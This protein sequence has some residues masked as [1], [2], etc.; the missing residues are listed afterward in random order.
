[1]IFHSPS[2]EKLFELDNANV[3]VVPFANNQMYAL[4]ETS[5]LVKVNPKNLNVIKTENV[6]KK[7]Y[8]TVTSIAHPH[9]EEDGSW[10]SIG[11]RPMSLNIT[12]DIMRYEAK[13]SKDVFDNPKLICQ[14][15]SSHT[16]GLSYFHSFALSQNYIIFL[17]QSL[18]LDIK[19]V[20]W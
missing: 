12:Y 1:M 2:K 6:Y 10:I 15:P 5:M 8:P 4:T 9:V 20:L 16:F 14:I 18:I 11:M 19:K 7:M 17:E 13:N 3:N